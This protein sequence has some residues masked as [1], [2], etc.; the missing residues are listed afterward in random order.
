MPALVSAPSRGASAGARW[1]EVAVV[2]ASHGRIPAQN[3]GYRFGPA[4]D[5]APARHAV[6]T[7]EDTRQRLSTRPTPP[8]R[9]RG[10]LWL[11]VLPGIMPLLIPVYNRIDP[12]LWGLP[13]FY[14]YLL[15]CGLASTVVIT[16]VYLVTKGRR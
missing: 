5:S 15:A 1:E 11:L 14:W 8:I 9:R 12:V 16:F 6:M 13:F 7:P 4:M 2:E 3:G 10:W